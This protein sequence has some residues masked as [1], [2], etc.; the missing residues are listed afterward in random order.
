M[1]TTYRW[2][3]EKNF[4][5]SHKTIN[6]I[7]P[8]SR[9]YFDVSIIEELNNADFKKFRKRFWQLITALREKKAV[10][11]YENIRLQSISHNLILLGPQTIQ[12]NLSKRCNYQ[13]NFCIV[14]SPL[15]KKKTKSSSDFAPLSDI[16]KIIRQAYSLGTEKIYLCGEGEP[17]LHPHILDIITYIAKYNLHITILTNGSRGDV[18]SKILEFPLSFNISFVVNLSAA[19]EKN[20]ALIYRKPPHMFSRVLDNIKNIAR[21]YPLTLS[22]LIYKDTHRDVLE[23]MRLACTLGV[24]DI[25]FK[26]PILYNRIQKKKLLFNEEKAMVLRNM[27]KIKNLA[28]KYRI[29]VE[30]NK[31]IIRFYSQKLGKNRVSSCFNGWFF[32]N[33]KVGGDL[34]IC[35]KENNALGKVVGG[36]FKNAFFSEQSVSYITDGA[37]GIDIN[38]KKWRKCKF[39][40]ENDRNIYLNSVMK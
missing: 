38:S 22:Y 3:L 20:F 33:I 40:L 35:C 1:P 5:L 2:R 29:N 7:K 19:N 21:R 27:D 24:K 31:Y 6:L 14:H 8:F 10:I 18:I 11:N 25:K 28:G 32:A 12:I 9:L 37:V 36:N 13:C 26:S 15:S 16:K 39:C 23:F 34:Y 30:F 4:K 17:L